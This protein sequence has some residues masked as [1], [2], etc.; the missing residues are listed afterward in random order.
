MEH[1][2]PLTGDDAGSSGPDRVRR[3]ARDIIE[4]ADRQNDI[5]RTTSLIHGHRLGRNL[6]G[7]LQSVAALPTPF[8]ESDTLLLPAAFRDYMVDATQRGILT[9][10]T[11][12]Q[13]ANAARER[14]EE[15]LRPVLAFDYDVVVDGATLPRP[16]NYSLVRIRPPDGFPPAHPELRPWVIIDP[17]SGQGSGIGGFK[18]NSEVGNALA[19]GYAVYFVIFEQFPKPDQTLSDV[20][21]AEAEFL[22]R[23]QALHP[24]TGRPFVTGN[25]QG[26]WAAMVLAATHPDLAGPIVIAGVPLSAWAGRMGQNPLR[27]LG[28]WLA[29]GL[30]AV[31]ASDLGGGLFDGAMLVAN[32]EAMNPSR[33]MWRKH[34]ELFGAIDEKG[35]EH[36]EFDRWWS[37]FYFMNA[38]EIRWIVEN[39]FV[40]NRL[41]RGLAHL[42]DDT[43]I[44]LTRIT[45][46]VIVFASHGDAV[47]TVQQ[48]LRWIPDVWESAANIRDAGRTIIYTT[49]DTASHLSIFV[50]AAVAEDHHKRIG[51]VMR[52]IE[53]L[54]PGLYEMVVNRGADGEVVHFEARE[55]DAILALCD[56][57]EM[58]ESFAVASEV[59]DW[60]TRGYEMT[61]GPWVRALSSSVSASLIRDLNPL[62]ATA[63]V[64]SDAGPLGTQLASAAAE[65]QAKRRPADETNPFRVA[66]TLLTDAVAQQIDLWHD[67]T[68]A[69]TEFGFHAL[70]ANPLL[71]P[72]PELLARYKAP[73]AETDG[74]E[75]QA[76]VARVDRGGYAEGIVRMCVILSRAGGQFRQDRLERFAAL[77]HT[78][79]PFDTMSAATRRRMIDEQS[80][81]V[82][83]AVQPAKDSL[84]RILRDDVDRMRAINL[85]LDVMQIG[86]DSPPDLI[87]AFEDLQLLLRTRARNWMTPRPG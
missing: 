19:E 78:R 44:D 58:D 52:T 72:R 2:F 5:S 81:I 45:S 43:R 9:L 31:V 25:C 75:A 26:G 86:P 29:G 3:I 11:L 82:D 17:R 15:G 1:P 68:E 63:R 80:L 14:E 62:R 57:V 53:A 21:A 65:V 84:M 69:A 47:S 60:L 4:R 39:I 50:S 16:V 76:A 85:V 40:G 64:L 13:A 48:A 54:P 56:P 23:V 34:A 79:A 67:L 22:H 8:A 36:L 30:P 35:A 7:A 77:L 10:D 37:G 51:S 73:P 42:D 49:H 66:E 18:H 33:D 71:R 87:E 20:T 55:T 70:Y 24:G 61:L 27:Y 59:A 32:F 46:P 74:Q 41:A 38:S 12:R 6:T 83:K 28:G